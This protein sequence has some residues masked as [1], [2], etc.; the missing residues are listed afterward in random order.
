MKKAL[1][2][3]LMILMFAMLISCENM[4]EVANDEDVEV[5]FEVTMPELEEGDYTFVIFGSFSDNLIKRANALTKQDDGLYTIT[6]KV[7]KD[8]EINYNYAILG[9]DEQDKTY[10]EVKNDQ[11]PCAQRTIVPQ[12]NQKISDIIER[13]NNVMLASEVEIVETRQL[14]DTNFY[15]N[16][17]GNVHTLTFVNKQMTVTYVKKAGNEYACIVRSIDE[18]MIGRLDT[19]TFSFKLQK[20]VEYLIKLEGGTRVQEEIVMGTGSSQEYVLKVRQGARNA[21]KI[22]IF[23]HRGLAGSDA[24]P[25]VG[26]YNLYSV[27]ASLK[28]FEPEKPY[29]PGKNPFHI[30]AIGNSF[31]DDGLW[32]LY[33][34]LED[35]GYDDIMV[36]NLYI[37]GCSVATHKS[38]IEHNYANYTYR[39]NRNGEWI[40]YNNYTLE[41]GLKDQR[42]DYISLQQASNYSG[43]L[44]YY[45]TDEIDYVYSYAKNIAS[46]LNPDVKLVWQMTWAYQQDST[47]GA[48]PSYNSDQMTMYNGII[49]CVQTV[50]ANDEFAPIIVPN[51]TTIQN[52][53]TSYIGDNITRDGYH[54]NEGFGR[55]AAALTFAA[56]LTNQDISAVRSPSSVPA[57]YVAL[58][59]EAVMNAVKN[60]YQVTPSIYQSEK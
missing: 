49:E 27:V 16:D 6:L 56:I 28:D 32:L 48:F 33:D 40:S 31:S 45:Q 54:L 50:I 52:L 39:L 18:D 58:C 24:K 21:T 19:I 53:R 17:G 57:K 7:A 5:T 34:I 37:G 30:L 29:E 13:F 26:A 36:A 51:G 47:H 10:V 42:W 2:L 44:D 8:Q 35:L 23:A 20:D 60:P 38:N 15:D 22:V 3:L 25:V 14:L 43:L 55:Y 46:L 41:A 12:N 4:G 9:L 1:H 59:K 11:T